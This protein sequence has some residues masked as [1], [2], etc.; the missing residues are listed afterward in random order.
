MHCRVRA[1]SFVGFLFRSS[2]LSDR[3]A[4]RNPN[5]NLQVTVVWHL[6]ELW[7]MDKDI[8]KQT[9]KIENIF[10]DGLKDIYKNL[11]TL[12]IYKRFLIYNLDFPVELTGIEDFDWE[13][14]YVLG[15]GSKKEYEL[16]KKTK[17]SYTDI[18]DLISIDNEFDEHFG[19]MANLTRKSDKK[20]FQIPLA[21]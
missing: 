2:V 10:P 11:D 16:L 7:N 6:T 20:T 4:L 18:Y 3:N 17:P 5:D 13:E 1:V 14:F 9:A 15:P 12:E 21:D 8:K 19:L